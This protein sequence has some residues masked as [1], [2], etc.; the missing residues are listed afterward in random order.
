MEAKQKHTNV[1]LEAAS[2]I[3]RPPEMQ[4][5]ISSVRDDLVTGKNCA[6]RTKITL[7]ITKDE[8]Y[9]LMTLMCN[10]ILALR[11]KPKNF[12]IDEFVVPILDAIYCR[13]QRDSHKGLAIV[14]GYGRGKSLLLEGYTCLHN[15]LVNNSKG[16]LRR[17]LFVYA[18]APRLFRELSA[19]CNMDYKS[20]MVIDELGREPLGGKVYGMESSPV[21][22]LLF[23]RYRVGAITHITSNC[24]AELLGSIYGPMLHSR[25][26]EMFEFIEMKGF[27]RRKIK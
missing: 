3:N 25:M 26:L 12:V 6:E 21:V 1:Y 27:D 14:G 17:P 23:E 15:S 19:N 9:E 13:T 11:G 22:D 4:R 24:D 20:P 16:Y 8:F 2:M 18:T 10:Q 5:V 7:P